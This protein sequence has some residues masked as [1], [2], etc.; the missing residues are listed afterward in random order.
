MDPLGGRDTWA[1]GSGFAARARTDSNTGGIAATAAAPEFALRV[2]VVA[3]GLTAAVAADEALG[4]TWVTGAGWLV[5]GVDCLGKEMSGP[6]AA[7]VAGVLVGAAIGRK[8]ARLA[9]IRRAAKSATVANTMT[10]ATTVNHRR[11]RASPGI[12]IG[13]S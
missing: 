5:S 4:A 13:S 12:S 7:R 8:D 2:A 3:E 11:R 10:S 1:A 9:W 6:G